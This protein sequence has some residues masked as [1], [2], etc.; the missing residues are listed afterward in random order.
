MK[1][2][3]KR[4]QSIDVEGLVNASLKDIAAGKT[5]CWIRL[6][7]VLA[8]GK[9]QT[10]V[11][12]DLNH[13]LTEFV[14]GK[15]ADD[16]RRN[17][18]RAAARSFLLNHTDGYAQIGRRTNYCDPGCIAVWLLRDELRENPVLKAAVAS[19]WIEALVGE[20]NDGSNRYQE[21]AALAYELNPDATLGGFIRILLVLAIVVVL[22]RVIQG[23][24]PIA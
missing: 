6:C 7:E 17:E 14:G 20:F 16:F 18:I 13:D 1:K 3:Q 21:M 22:F 23:R 15:E 24:R 8:L 4:E 5:F 10:A 12:H 11:F 9:G 19:N 2:A